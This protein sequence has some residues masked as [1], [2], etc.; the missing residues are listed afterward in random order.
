MVKTKHAK[1]VTFIFSCFFMVVVLFLCKNLNYLKK[2]DAPAFSKS[3]NQNQEPTASHDAKIVGV[4]VPYMDLEI[5]SPA[6]IQESFKEKFQNIISESKKRGINTLIVHVRSHND[7]MYPSK[8]FPWSHLITGNQG[9]NPGF[10][11]LSYMIKASHENGLKFHAWINPLRIQSKTYPKKLSEDNP[12]FKLGSE[13][14]FLNH[15]DGVCYNPA[16]VETRKLVVDGVREIVQNYDIDAIHF[17]D[18]FYPE[19]KNLTSKDFAYDEH[20]KNSTEKLDLQSWRKKNINILIKE[21]YDAIKS[22]NSNV[23]F[24]ISPA[25]NIQKCNEAGADVTLWASHCGYIDYICPQIYW[26]TDYSGMPFEKT[27][28]N[29]KNMLK[30][31]KVKIYGGLALYKAG[32]DLDNGTWKNHS[33]ILATELKM[34]EKLNYDGLI[35]YSWGFLN[36]PSAKEEMNNLQREL[37]KISK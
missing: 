20:L 12:Y 29:W 17:D 14:Y 16:H 11:P 9:S 30:N 36:S 10:D 3:H 22:I 18:Y 5:N 24:G 37:M 26:S 25:G 27:A 2:S 32:T 19:E 13:K 35:I 8:I 28:T 31:S 23:L 21:T 1:S 6:N 15:T 4:W 33:S 7:A 34:I